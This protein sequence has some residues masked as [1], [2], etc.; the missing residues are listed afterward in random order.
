MEKWLSLPWVDVTWHIVVI[1]AAGLVVR[2]IAVRAIRRAVRASSR[3]LYEVT[4]PGAKRKH[5]ARAVTVLAASGASPEERAAN[6]SDTLTR[7]LC[8][9]VNWVI[10]VIIALTVFSELGINLTPFLTSAGVTG[11]ILGL[12]AQSLIKDLIA[13]MFMVFEGQYSIGDTID[14]GGVRGVVQEIGSRVTRLQGADGEVWYV[15]HGEIT[16]LGN[17]SQGWLT[18]DVAITVPASSDSEQVTSALRQVVDD[19]EDDPTWHD[20]MLRPPVFLGLTSFDTKQM[21]FTIRVTSP[22]QSGVD[23]EVR[24]RAVAALNIAES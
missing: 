1:V 6:R 21:V 10:G 13:G 17:Q 16:T 23:H 7:V 14:A 9:V 18:T 3:R 8:L 2:F 4:V 20:K 12:G 19:L 11:V 15:R 22:K 24:A 5:S